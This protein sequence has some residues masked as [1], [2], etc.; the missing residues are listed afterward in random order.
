MISTAKFLSGMDTGI[1]RSVFPL[2]GPDNAG[3]V[4]ED[5]FQLGIS[6]SSQLIPVAQ[7]ERRLG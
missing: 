7:E 2:L 4:A 6:L 5:C 3:V 1:L